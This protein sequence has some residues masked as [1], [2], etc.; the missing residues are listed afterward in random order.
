MSS[1]PLQTALR[2]L[3]R[4]AGRQEPGRSDAHLLER[5]AGGDEAAFELL[6]WRHGPMVLCTCRRVLC[7]EQDAEDAFQVTFLTLARKAGAIGKAE[8]VG[9][10]LYKVAYRAALQV[11]AAAE[12]RPASLPPGAEPAAPEEAPPAELRELRAALDEEV[13]RLPEEYRAP[14]VLCYLEGRTYTEAARLLNCPAGTVAVRLR[15]ARERLRGRLTRRGLAVPAGLVA[16]ALV[17]AAAPAAVP[18]PLMRAALEAATGPA[19]ARLGALTEGVIRAMFASKLKAMTAA[20]VVALAVLGSGAGALLSQGPARRAVQ[21]QPGP[22][23]VAAKQRE[24]KGQD[25]PA[26]VS[27]VLLFV[28]TDVKPGEKVPAALL[29]KVKVDGKEWTYR[30]LRVGDRV[31]EGQLLARVDDRPARAEVDAKRAM[32]EAAKAD[33]R[34]AVATRDEAKRRYDA[35]VN[36]KKRAA[37]AVSEEEVSA[38]KLTWDRYKEEERARAAGVEAAAASLKIA[39]T[40]LERHEIRAS[41]RG[42]IKHIYKNRGEAVKNLEPVLRIVADENAPPPADV[43]AGR[44]HI[45]VPAERGG[46]LLFLGTEIQPGEK[47]PANR[48]IKVER[49]FLAVDITDDPAEV[50]KTPEAERVTFTDNPRKYRRWKDGDK[51]EP[52]KVVLA[53]QPR[54]YRRLGS[55]DEV[56]EGHSYSAWSTRLWRWTSCR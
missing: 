6:L 1:L 12:R 11:R 26:E 28:G 20:V 3:R 25:V 40:I 36:T 21:A 15:R 14:V 29:L 53:R 4:V 38:A 44:E 2:H 9:S 23:P 54:E 5:F 48:R 52:G 31:E 47:V 42:V 45:D 8:S 17:P 33:H 37:G 51:I 43:G 22:E 7:R 34:A 35:L 16:A 13:G 50:A 30:R 32:L 27:G 19:P 49:G 46:R 55:G 10:W 41:I 56:K 39:Q 24:P 18:A